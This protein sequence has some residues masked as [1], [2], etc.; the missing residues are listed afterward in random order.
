[1][2]TRPLSTVLTAAILLGGTVAASSPATARAG[3]AERAR[4]AAESGRITYV[5]LADDAASMAAATRSVQAA[6]GTVVDRNADISSL[7]VTAAADGFID[8]ALAGAGVAGVARNRSI[9]SEPGLRPR[10]DLIE[11]ETGGH[12]GRRPG[13]GVPA[14]T[15]TFESLQWDMQM[16]RADVART[17]NAGSPQVLVGIMDTGVDASNPDLAPNF[18]AA[19]S[20][21]FVTDM[22]D[23]DGPCEDPSC[24]D[25]ADTDDGGHGTHVAGTVAAA[26]NGMGI[27]G[28]AP[29]VRLVNI[30]AG[31]DSGYF[32]LQASLDALT[33]AGT[34][35][36]DVVNMSFYVDPWLYNCQDNPADSP[37]AQ[38]EQQT[39]V[40][41][42]N[43][44]LDFAHR[45]GVT[46]VAAMGNEHTDLGKPGIDATSPDYPA[47]TA[48]DRTID[49]ETC[50]S[51]PSEGNHVLNVTSVGPSK[52]KADYSNYGLE[53]AWVAAPGGWFRDGYGTPTFRT[54]G[55]LILS[56]YPLHVLQEEGSV[57][58]D[59]NVVPDAEGL[60][61]KDCTAA[62]ACGYYTYLQGT[63]MASPHAAGVAALAVSRY[64]HRDPFR[65]GRTLAPDLTA[66][67][68]ARA[69]TATPCPNPPLQSYADEGRDPSF[70]TLCEGTTRFN[71][72]YGSGIIDAAR[73]VGAR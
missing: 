64:G 7:T 26:A 51:M 61:F 18:D 10:R 22:P 35:G 21:N 65:G 52:T 13:H 2:R 5:V 19:R 3:R 69:A 54:N 25:P 23:I 53:H 6:G 45:R 39:I 44:A 34:T 8:R 17:V 49:N 59:G 50:L 15:D 38:Q 28:V 68:V 60:V 48:Y 31:Q 11:R 56:T 40:R 71:G 63:S 27:V 70:D 66:R 57:D 4:P 29:K 32:F 24:V 43:R 30:R 46:L 72:F 55:N 73:V 62:G 47:D 67:I 16:I 37:E 9:G 14:G 36:I 41:A 12:Q 42:M 1:M 58:Q 33:Y 20:R